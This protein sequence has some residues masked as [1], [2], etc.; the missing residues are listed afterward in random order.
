MARML[1]ADPGQVE[2]EDPRTGKVSFHPLVEAFPVAL[3]SHETAE[4]QPM[5][6]RLGRAWRRKVGSRRSH[7]GD[8]ANEEAAR[9]YALHKRMFMG[10]T[11][12]SRR[13]ET[14]AMCSRFLSG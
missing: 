8:L 6:L 7:S 5:G 1:R 4:E 2:A 3:F 13:P 9:S 11:P 10:C 12:A 14:G